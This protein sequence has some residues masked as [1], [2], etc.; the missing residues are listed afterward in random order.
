MHMKRDLDRFW[1]L[2]FAIMDVFVIESNGTCPLAGDGMM[3]ARLYSNLDLT[4]TALH[5]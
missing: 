5:A 1:S 2:I 3:H 4:K